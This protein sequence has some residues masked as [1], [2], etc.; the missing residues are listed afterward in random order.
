MTNNIY[1]DAHKVMGRKKNVNQKRK[2]REAQIVK[3]FDSTVASSRKKQRLQ[4]SS[5]KDLFFVDDGAVV[6]KKKKDSKLTFDTAKHTKGK[7]KSS[8]GLRKQEENLSDLWGNDDA[9][10]ASAEKSHVDHYVYMQ[11][12][13][14]AEKKAKAK[15]RKKANENYQ[16]KL[17]PAVHVA[18]AGASYNPSVADHRRL[19]QEALEVERKRVEGNIAAAKKLRPPLPPV[20]DKLVLSDNEED[21]VDAPGGLSINPAVKREKKLTRAQRNKRA[22][23]K[24]EEKERASLKVAKVK[25][26]QLSHLKEIGKEIKRSASELEK[27]REMVTKMREE[28]KL[29]PKAVKYGNTVVENPFPIDAPLSDELH[30]SLRKVRMV[31]NPVRDRLH[32]MMQRNLVEV[33]GRRRGKKKGSTFKMMDRDKKW[34]LPE[35]QVVE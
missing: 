4:T 15:A 8:G 13:R 6:K 10:A 30:G 9:D 35:E 34:K 3:D 7:K 5:N 17:A 33:G 2:V 16:S 20:N 19:I 21:D 25:N 27:K 28:K 23:L 22:R 14:E 29:L 12:S 26:S 31:G 32:S 11:V 24:R 18:D 1:D